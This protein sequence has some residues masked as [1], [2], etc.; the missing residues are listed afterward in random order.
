VIRL[1]KKELEREARLPQ[2]LVPTFVARALCGFLDAVLTGPLDGPGALRLGVATGPTGIG[3]TFAARAW[4]TEWFTLYVS[5]AGDG[6]V[7]RHSVLMQIFEALK[8]HPDGRLREAADNRLR[9]GGPRNYDPANG[10]QRIKRALLPLNDIDLPLMVVIDEAQRL[11]QCGVTVCADLAEAG[12]PFALIGTDELRDRL[13]HP[14]LD[15]K[16]K[17]QWA[18][19]VSRFSE[20]LFL[21]PVDRLPIEDDREA[22]A[23]AAGITE[24]AAIAYL[25]RLVTTD[26]AIREAARLIARAVRT[27]NGAPVKVSHLKAAVE[28]WGLRP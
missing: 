19:V 4:A 3:K 22:L 7:R 12:V 15:E 13:F 10:Y 28:S 2:G 14:D 8:D 5:V 11:T 18:P 17:Q 1:P 9:D 23:R 16:E 26:R 27:A 24:P 20:R 6:Q 21:P 25:R